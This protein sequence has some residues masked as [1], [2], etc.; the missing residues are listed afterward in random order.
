MANESDSFICDEEPLSVSLETSS[1]QSE[2]EGKNL[3][4]NVS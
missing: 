2:L 4:T 1:V 3:K